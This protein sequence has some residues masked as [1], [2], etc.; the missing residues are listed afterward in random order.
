MATARFRS[1]F[2]YLAGGFIA[3]VLVFA[4]VTP[5]RA[6][7]AGD[8][9]TTGIGLEIADWVPARDKDYGG[10][11]VVAA[12]DSIETPLLWTR[13]ALALK[14]AP[15][16]YD[17]YWV[18]DYDTLDKP[19]LL[20]RDVSV[21]ADRLTTV[22]VDS[23][24]GIEVAAW[25]PARDLDY[26]WWGAASVESA[27]AGEPVAKEQ[28]VNWTKSADALLLPPGDYDIYWV[29]DYDTLG[30]P[31]LLAEGLIVEAG[32]LTTVDVDSGVRIEVATWLPAR[33]LDYGWWGAARVESAT[34]GEPVTKEQMVNWTKTADALVLPP[35]DYDI[36]WVQDYD[37]LDIPIL[38]TRGVKV[39]AGQPVAVMADS[40]VR[41]EVAAW[42]P[43]RDADYGWWGAASADSL[44][45]GEP[46]TTDQLVNWT[47]TAEALLLPPGAYD[48]YWVQNYPNLDKPIIIAQGVTVSGAFGGIGIEIGLRD[49]VIKVVTPLAGGAADLAGIEAGDII[50]AV[51]GDSLKGKTLDQAVA[52]L[53]GAI[54]AA[55]TLTIRRDDAELEIAIERAAV[56]AASL[57]RVNTGIQPVLAADTPPLDTDT[58]WWGATPAWQGPD[59]RVNWSEGQ[60][61]DPLVLPPG[62]YDIYWRLDSSGEPEL[63]ARDV[64]VA[65]GS[66]IEV[67]I[68]L[69][70]IVVTPTV[71]VAFELR[72]DDGSD[73]VG[74]ALPEGVKEIE[75]RY[76]WENAAIG[77]RLGVRWLFDDQ[78]VLEQ[79]EPV[80]TAAGETKWA[81]KSDDGSALP[82][83]AYRVELMEEGELRLP[84]EFGIGTASEPAVDAEP[85]A[86]DAAR[87]GSVDEP[88]PKQP[89]KIEN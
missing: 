67:P 47:R 82:Q 73:V 64:S 59:N 66:L 48:I 25:V 89:A 9:G 87:E 30:R 42:V 68:G 72:S 79:G 58:G 5:L 8:G 54:G 71:V 76:E 85:V 13:D 27:T 77:H 17:V 14:L 75:V 34:A 56:S 60:A 12:G 45:A 88:K 49:G 35:G 55:V 38:L 4:G 26:G 40:G 1:H 84:V 69:A 22:D 43:A 62:R 44:T 21:E 7:F 51:D 46:V 15:G 52:R 31:I 65:L 37:T 10:W 81:L 29:Q 11:G 78:V 19:I 23:G 61:D 20:A 74:G 53:R 70:S 2:A 41:I 16:L 3:L 33:D 83:G 39:S 80:A 57:V 50:V 86:E 6:Q 24:V 18:Q 28:M 36:Y 32:R 63:K